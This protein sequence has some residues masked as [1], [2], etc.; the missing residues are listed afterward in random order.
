MLK[1]KLILQRGTVTSLKFVEFVTSSHT[2]ERYSLMTK[3]HTS[4]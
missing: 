3:T 2:N 4:S 1:L